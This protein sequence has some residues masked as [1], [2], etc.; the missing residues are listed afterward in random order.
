MIRII[1]TLLRAGFHAEQRAILRGHPDLE[2][3]M[4]ALG[5]HMNKILFSG[6]DGSSLRSY[7]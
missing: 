6:D 4:T 5:E 1:D 7:L 2:A 3:V